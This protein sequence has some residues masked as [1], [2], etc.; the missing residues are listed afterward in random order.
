[1]ELRPATL[2]DV[3]TI[4]ALVRRAQAHDRVP[5]VLSD[6]ELADDL[7]PRTSTWSWTRGSPSAVA[8]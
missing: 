5:Q 2:D 3:P 8:R 7:R 6:E 4:A 1:M